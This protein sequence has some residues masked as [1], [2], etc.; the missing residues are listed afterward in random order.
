MDIYHFKGFESKGHL[1]VQTIMKTFIVWWLLHASIL[2]NT[3][4]NGQIN[5]VMI[6]ALIRIA[7]WWSYLFRFNNGHNKYTI[8][9]N[10]E[11]MP[12]FDLN[13]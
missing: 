4:A 3:E 5:I 7:P 9:L 13:I 6:I 11:D 12:T 2:Q 1:K 10:K 8:S